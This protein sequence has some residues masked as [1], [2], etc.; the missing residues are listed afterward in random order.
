MVSIDNSK[1]QVDSAA[2]DGY[3]LQPCRTVLHSWTFAVNI[4][5]SFLYIDTSSYSSDV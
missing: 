1:L 4:V 2:Q 3:G 5:S